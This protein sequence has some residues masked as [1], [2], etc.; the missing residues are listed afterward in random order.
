MAKPPPGPLKPFRRGKHFY[1]VRFS[2]LKFLRSL[3]SSKMMTCLPSE[4][5]P[6]SNSDSIVTAG[7]PGIER[8]LS[9]WV[10]TTSILSTKYRNPSNT[11]SL[12]FLFVFIN[13][14]LFTFFQLCKLKQKDVTKCSALNENDIPIGSYLRILGSQSVE[15]FGVW[16]CWRRRGHRVQ[17]SRLQSPPFIPSALSASCLRCGM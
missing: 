17:A 12:L 9:T 15:L 2:L 3:L 4:D 8:E 10:D 6:G 1:P 14:F 13:L 7:L 11:A 5:I 16:T